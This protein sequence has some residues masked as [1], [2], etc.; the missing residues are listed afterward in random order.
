MQQFRHENVLTLIGV[1][2][3]GNEPML[4]LPFMKNGDLLTYIR[5]EDNSPTLR[6]LLQFAIDVG[7]GMAY[8]S[9]MKYVHRDLAARNCM[10]DESLRIKVGDFGLT[11]D[12][13]ERSYY[14]ANEHRE[15]PIRWMS[16]EAIERN[17]ETTMSD[18]SGDSF[19]Q[20]PI[21]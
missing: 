17:R 3:S 6:D 11:R 10:M 7:N 12:V 13:Y 14:V 20:S 9:A 5:S 18:V 8:L 19:P 16:I 4:V 15:L 1:C 2:I 21:R